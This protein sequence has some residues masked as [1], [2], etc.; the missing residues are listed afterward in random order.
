MV[1]IEIILVGAAVLVLISIFA[2]KISEWLGVPALLIFLL[3]GMKF[4]LPPRMHRKFFASCI[5]CSRGTG[6]TPRAT[7][8][9]YGDILKRELIATRSAR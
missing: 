1:A 4:P 8:L 2:N 7:L 3:V 6:N 9:D 5:G